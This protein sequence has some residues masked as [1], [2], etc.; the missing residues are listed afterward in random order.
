MSRSLSRI[1][2]LI[3]EIEEI[4]RQGQQGGHSG[5]SRSAQIK[6]Q[7]VAPLK[8]IPSNEPPDP[9]LALADVVHL[10]ESRD[11]LNETPSQGKVALKLSG[12]VTLSLQI[13]NAQETIEIKQV[14]NLLE[15]RFADGKAFHL[16]LKAVA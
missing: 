6:P 16:P 1:R 14:G 9:F 2:S 10:D 4:H 8:E 7:P 15:I 12:T 3:S 13:E 5:L 11:A